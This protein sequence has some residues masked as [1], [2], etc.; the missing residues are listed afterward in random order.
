MG[1]DF[2]WK[3]SVTAHSAEPNLDV[4]QRV[5]FPEQKRTFPGQQL[6]NCFFPP[7]LPQ[8]STASQHALGW[9][10]FLIQLHSVKSSP[11]V[12]AFRFY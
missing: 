7:L 5:K 3:H 8:C 12:R 10:S 1:A 11:P 2:D 4:K 9:I 6:E